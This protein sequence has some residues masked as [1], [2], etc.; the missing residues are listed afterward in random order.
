MNVLIISANTLPMSPLGAA[1]IAGSALEA[2]HGVAV[3]DC[4]LDQGD[5]NRFLACLEQFEPDVVGLSIPL[6]TCRIPENPL[7]NGFCFTDIRP[8]LKRLVTLV[9]QRTDALVVAGGG[10]FNYFPADWLFCLDI[11]YGLVGECELSFPLF[12]EACSHEK[13]LRRVPGII[14]RS[15]ENMYTRPWQEM[16]TLD[17]MPLPAWHLFDTGLYNRMGVPWGMVTKRG[18]SFRCTWCSSCFSQDQTCRIK[19]PDRIL[20]E[21]QHI[22]THTGSSAV[23]FCDFSFNCPITHAKTLCKTLQEAEA[24]IEWR[25]GTFKPLG[26]SLE[27]CSMIRSS[28]CRFAGLSIDTASSR[29][30]ANMN[31]GYRKEDI[32]SA[33]EHLAESGIDH[34]VSLVI[35]APGETMASI[36]ETFDLIESYP[37]IKAVWVNIGVFGLKR[38][39]QSLMPDTEKQQKKPGLFQDAW[40][41]SPELDRDE[42]EDFIETLGEN[43]NFFVQINKPWAGD[44]A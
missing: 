41:I 34:G 9:R 25:S 33:L 26:I 4:L 36:R 32:R 44:T 16:K 23:N 39:L 30:L 43:K 2:G 14:I 7:P 15:G 37:D 22:K 5:E 20:A 27:F 31:R 10:G 21:I 24:D 3:F 29:L 19:S 28:R 17:A 11:E 1:Y 13:A 6:V 35:G 38:H 8:M 12:L 18:C 42:M 40:Y